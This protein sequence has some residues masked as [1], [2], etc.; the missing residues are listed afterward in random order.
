MLSPLTKMQKRN[1]IL[2]EA[3]KIPF[4]QSVTTSLYLKFLW[5]DSNPLVSLVQIHLIHQSIILSRDT[6]QT[7]GRRNRATSLPTPKSRF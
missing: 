3:K 1:R 5:A 4:M 6:E 2:K 7:R